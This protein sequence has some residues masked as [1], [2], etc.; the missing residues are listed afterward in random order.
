[1]QGCPNHSKRFAYK[2]FQTRAFKNYRQYNFKCDKITGGFGIG[3]SIVKKIC[4]KNGVQ[5]EVHSEPKKG[6]AFL[7][8]FSP[9]YEI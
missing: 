7:F 3:L 4:D 9:R 1:M 8:Y 2:F 6:S 5:V